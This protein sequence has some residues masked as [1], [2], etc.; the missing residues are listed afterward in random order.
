MSAAPE[1]T[2]PARWA[3]AA[4]TAQTVAQGG[5]PGPLAMRHHGVMRW[6]VLWVMVACLGLGG[7]T[8][9]DPEDRGL[10]EVS[11]TTADSARSTTTSGV[12]SCVAPTREP[13]TPELDT[14]VKVFLFCGAGGMPVDLRPVDRVVPNDGAPLRAALTQLLLGVTPAEAEAGMQSAF[15]AYT[16]GTLRG[17]TIE[18]GMATLDF[19]AGFETTNNFSTTNLSGVVLSQ[20]VATVSQFPEITSIDYEIEGERWCGWEAGDCPPVPV[21]AR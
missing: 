2:R 15:S 9:D 4:L 6:G 8:N 10:P 13:R 20:I 18:S 7:C 1:R 14:K 19:R 17:V 16:A 11:T 5:P 12:A 3:G 21:A